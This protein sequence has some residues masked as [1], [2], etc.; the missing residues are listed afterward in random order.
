MDNL[1]PVWKP[2]QIKVQKLCAGD[3]NRQV[4]VRNNF[5]ESFDW[6]LLIILLFIFSNINELVKPVLIVNERNLS[7]Y[8]PW[9]R[10]D[11]GLSFSVRP[12]VCPSVCLSRLMWGTLSTRVWYEGVEL[13]L[14][15]CVHAWTKVWSR[16]SS[17]F[18]L[19]R[20]KIVD[21]VAL[22][23]LSILNFFFRCQALCPREFGMKK[24]S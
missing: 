21:S 16:A 13:E 19:D 3:Y 10:G 9:K 12:S 1:N 15:N 20:L 22:W 17:K 4:R 2:F 6:D 23:K 8:P 18:Y 24:L 14:S 11:I 7:N 5:I